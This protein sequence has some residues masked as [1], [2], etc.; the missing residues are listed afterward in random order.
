MRLMTCLS[1]TILTLV[2]ACSDT[3]SG[4][5]LDLDS[6]FQNLPN[7]QLERLGDVQ[8]ED[9]NFSVQVDYME[10]RQLFISDTAPESKV[11]GEYDTD[12]KDSFAESLLLNLQNAESTTGVG[13]Q[14]LPA[15]CVNYLVTVEGEMVTVFDNV[16]DI[17][18]LIGEV[19]TPAEIHL[20]LLSTDFSAELYKETDDGFQ[21]IAVLNNCGGTIVK[22]L[23]EIDSLGNVTELRVVSETVTN[24]VC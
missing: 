21:V 7:I 20:V 8:L 22:T 17:I 4:D 5:D 2:S 6:G 23:L 19:D 12:I 9:F 24:T 10:W 11:I 14:C 1:L 18:A 13:L 16:L 15:A 3:G